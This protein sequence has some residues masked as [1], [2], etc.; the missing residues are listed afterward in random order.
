MKLV[1]YVL[2]SD[3]EKLQYVGALTADETQIVALQKA[4]Q[5]I[6]GK[7][8]PYFETM[9]D[10]LT[11][12]EDARTLAAQ[13]L[14]A[15][16]ADCKIAVDRVKLLA[17]VP[18][19]RVMRDT[20]CFEEHLIGCA[21][22]GRIMRGEDPAA[23]DPESLKPGADWYMEPRFYKSNV[24]AI[25]GTGE[26]V[27]FP[28]GE[29][30][31]D[32]ELEMAFYICKEGKNISYRDAMDYVGGYT[33]F[34]DFSARMT[35]MAETTQ[36][37]LNVGPG[38][39]KDFANAMGPCMTTPDAFD[40]ENAQMT[41]R[42][43]GEVRGGGNHGSCHH[44]I[45]D[46][47]A[48][49]SNNTTLYPGDVIATGTVGTGAAI[50][51]GIPLRVGDVVELEIEGIGKLINTIAAPHPGKYKN[52][53]K[54]HKRFVCGPV[55]GK[56]KF[57]IDDYPDMWRPN[58]ERPA[59][60]TWRVNEMPAAASATAV[61]DMGNLP[62]EHEP[63]AGSGQSIF[64]HVPF[65]VPEGPN[66]EDLPAEKRTALRDAW[67]E[68]HKVIG[69]KYIP[70]EEDMK[71]HVSMHMAETLNML[72]CAEGSLTTLND[73]EDARL[74]SG[75]ALI[76][77]ANMHGY[78][79]TGISS[80]ILASADMST[81]TQQAEKPKAVLKSKLNRFHRVVEGTLKSD[82]KKMGMSDVF[83]DDYAPNESEIYSKDGKHIGY[84]GDIWIMRGPNGHVSG[85]AD[86]VVGPIEP[87]PP[88]AGITYRMVDLLPGCTF[89][90]ND[91]F[92][93]YYSVITGQLEVSCDE[94]TA[95]V[96]TTGDVIQ[97]KDARVT[98]SNPTGDTVRFAH[99]MI[100]TV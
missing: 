52:T 71:K 17:P 75:D 15:A 73:L 57:V 51:T 24:N 44:K 56:S 27:T 39:G 93:S 76:Q 13:L 12:A 40:P 8:S 5:A 34:N 31:K 99:F 82:Q 9:I 58:G 53:K 42:V 18:R 63:H 7:P 84:A 4:S 92:L 6:C 33:I 96:P 60:D 79:G 83:F 95:T 46:I 21:R 28:E 36:S 47:I 49:I 86:T 29:M 67:V 98:L 50:E 11:G 25:I 55:D 97:L 94:G 22:R 16:G 2:N 48:Y 90:T 91:S 23:I 89:E 77:L 19:P 68:A 70:T 66:F 14:A 88:K 30:F 74:N 32:Y 62:V 69:T 1:T 10:F 80:G 38:R 72:F 37:S 100:D 85:G 35:Q 65:N 26:A 64:R 78:K 45:P 54:A 59:L 87:T 41:V 81:F 20:A 43:N 3:S 61:A